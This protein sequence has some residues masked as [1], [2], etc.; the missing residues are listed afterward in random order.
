[1][2]Y[3]DHEI[4]YSAGDNSDYLYILYSGEILRSPDVN[5]KSSSKY[6]VLG[7]LAVLTGTP[8]HETA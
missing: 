1:M 5:V 6:M 7:E 3:R 8:Y 2:K 4:I